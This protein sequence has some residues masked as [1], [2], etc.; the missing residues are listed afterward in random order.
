MEKRFLSGSFVVF[1]FLLLF[2][3]CKKDPI[4]A[5]FAG[6]GSVGT[7]PTSGGSNN[8]VPIARAGNDTTIYVPFSNY[9]LNGWASTDPNGTIKSYAWRLVAGP[10]TVGIDNNNKVKAFVRGMVSLGVYEFE[11]T[12]TDADGLTS[13]DSIKITIADPPCNGPAKEAVFKDLP[14]DHSWIMEIDFFNFFSYLPPNSYLRNIYI[15]RD[16]S[17][18]WEKVVCLDYN[19]PDYGKV[20]EWEYGNGVLVIFPG[21]N[22]TD[23]TPDVKIEYCN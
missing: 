16:G 7:G 10:S 12:V 9:N 13:K 23:D 11:L 5:G 15:K 21:Q 3:S 14:W 20:H 8:G 6:T 17:N 2:T 19:A 18:N 1:S 22:M 4:D